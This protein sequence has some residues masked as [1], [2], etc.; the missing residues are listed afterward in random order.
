MP[1]KAILDDVK[2]PVIYI[3]GGPTD[4]AYENG[5]DDFSRLNDIPVVAINYPVGHGGTYSQLHGGEFSIP[6]TAWLQWQLKGDNEAAKMF[7]G[8]SCGISTREG[9]TIEKKN[10]D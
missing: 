3:L 4:I 6:A 2:V 5:M 10:I 9:W 7:Q 8:E 1:D